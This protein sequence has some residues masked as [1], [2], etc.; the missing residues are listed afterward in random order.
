MGTTAELRSRCAGLQGSGYVVATVR[1][2]S[3]LT[4]YVGE[5]RMLS[6]SVAGEPCDVLLAC[7]E[8]GAERLIEQLQQRLA[9]LRQRSSSRGSGQAEEV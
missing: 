1:R 5:S 8:A 9:E 2:D 6:L 7:T 4:S 3:R